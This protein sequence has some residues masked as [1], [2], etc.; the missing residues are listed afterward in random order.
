MKYR[1]A[2]GLNLKVFGSANVERLRGSVLTKEEDATFS[3]TRA[4][5]I[6]YST[7]PFGFMDRLISDGYDV[8]DFNWINISKE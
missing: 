6:F 2:M 1:I 4:T 8:D 5:A 7:D 3:L